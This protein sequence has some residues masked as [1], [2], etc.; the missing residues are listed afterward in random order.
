MKGCNG[1]GYRLLKSYKARVQS[2]VFD[3]FKCTQKSIIFLIFLH[4]LLKKRSITIETSDFQITT[5]Y[6][7][8]FVL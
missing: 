1:E 7:L 5:L 4:L 8:L 2:L 6:P 3:I